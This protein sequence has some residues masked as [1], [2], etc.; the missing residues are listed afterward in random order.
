[1]NEKIGEGQ[2]IQRMLTI[3]EVAERSGV[4]PSAIRYYEELGLIRSER[5]PSGHRRFGREI[6]RRLAFIVFA[7]RIGL[8]LAEVAQELRRLPSGRVP[9][10]ADWSKLSGSWAKRIEK[11]I[12]DL[13]RL[14]HDLSLCIGCGCLSL[15]SCTIANPGDQAERFGPGPARWKDEE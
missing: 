8:T 2:V 5:A 15:E 12:A 14:R 10:G 1:M 9:T 4:A 7:Q 13:E 11:R 6:L 3:G